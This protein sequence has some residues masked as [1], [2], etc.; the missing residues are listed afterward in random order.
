MKNAVRRGR[1]VSLALAGLTLV[2]TSGCN[3]LS[4]RQLST[5]LQSVMT[6]GLS[7]LVSTIISTAA[8]Q[9]S[10]TQSTGP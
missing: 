8:G 5:M 7:T 2:G 1:L 6:T 9:V 10:S 3:G 4:D